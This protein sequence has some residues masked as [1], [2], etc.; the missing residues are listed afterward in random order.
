[1]D[2]IPSEKLMAPDNTS[3]MTPRELCIE[4]W[5]KIF[6]STVEVLEFH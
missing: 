6:S 2:E 1:M 4:A 3:L 5:K